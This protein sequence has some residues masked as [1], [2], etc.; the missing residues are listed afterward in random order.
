M[1]IMGD[2]GKKPERRKKLGRPRKPLSEKD[3]HALFELGLIH[4]TWVEIAAVIGRDHDWL[5]TNYREI[6]E[7]GRE[8][9]KMR[10][11]QVQLRA[12]L[13]GNIVMMIWLGKQLLGQRDKHEITGPD[14]GAFQIETVRAGIQQMMGDSD[15]GTLADQLARRMKPVR[16]PRRVDAKVLEDGRDGGN[17]NGQPGAD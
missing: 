13:N 7:R 5:R 12:A 1:E 9:G 6:V 4:C 17:G 2:N 8:Q 10:L 16:L 14:G 11:R 15:M 3:E